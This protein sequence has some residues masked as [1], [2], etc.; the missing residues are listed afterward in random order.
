LPS[1]M[2]GQLNSRLEIVLPCLVVFVPGSDR[3]RLKYTLVFP[4]S[5]C[6]PPSPAL[7]DFRPPPF[8]ENLPSSLSPFF[9]G[10]FNLPI[11]PAPLAPPFFSGPS[12]LVQ[13]VTP[14]CVPRHF[15]LPV[16]GRLTFRRTKGNT[17]FFHPR[18]VMSGFLFYFFFFFFFLLFLF[19]FFFFSTLTPG[20]PSKF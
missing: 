19:F 7:S 6:C 13:K 2:E 15:R 9:A 1:S 10:P 3:L 12:F 8:F 20:L 5:V 18:G 17:L 14:G 11:F 16:K 4:Q